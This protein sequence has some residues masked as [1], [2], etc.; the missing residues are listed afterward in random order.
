MD[1]VIGIG[2]LVI[3]NFDLDLA[4]SRHGCLHAL[5]E[6]GADV[7]P[8]TSL[9]TVAS[10]TGCEGCV[11]LLLKV[12]TDVDSDG[13][14]LH[15]AAQEGHHKCL[16]LLLRSGVKVNIHYMLSYT[17]FYALHHEVPKCLETLM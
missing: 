9:L 5:L 2:T 1:G 6:A 15:V 11:D 14:T 10:L 13:I 4:A 7:K 12:G 8:H 16:E 17:L 3:Y